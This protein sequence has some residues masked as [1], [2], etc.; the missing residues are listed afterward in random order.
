MKSPFQVGDDRWWQ[1]MTDM[2][3]R[4]ARKTLRPLP[5]NAVESIR[6]SLGKGFRGVVC[7][8]PTRVGKRV[9]ASKIIEGAQSKGKRVIFTAPAMSLIDQTVN[10]FGAERLVDIDVMQAN[11]ARPDRFAPLQVASGQTS[12]RREI[13][14]LCSGPSA[15]APE[16]LATP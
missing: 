7:A 2:F 12:A 6:Q 1:A 3:R 13:P 9:T 15:G 8:M 10:A 16:T 5:I 4:S 14:V 11:H